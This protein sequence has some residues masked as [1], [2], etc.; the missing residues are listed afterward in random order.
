MDVSAVIV[1][2]AVYL[3]DVGED[4]LDC[5]VVV[6]YSERSLVV[7]RDDPTVCPELRELGT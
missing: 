3:E 7:P 2:A 6:V 4:G 5:D 1:G